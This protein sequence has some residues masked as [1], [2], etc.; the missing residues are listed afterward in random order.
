MTDLT[1]G[2]FEWALGALKAGKKVRLSRWDPVWYLAI[3]GSGDSYTVRVIKPDGG[4]AMWYGAVADILEDAWELYEPGHDFAWAL[5]QIKAGK[6]V[7]RK[8]WAYDSI[9]IP[10]KSRMVSMESVLADDWLLA[11]DEP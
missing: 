5:E 2:T 4:S 9:K 10:V 8:A 6:S 1:P 7:R 11:E 3:E